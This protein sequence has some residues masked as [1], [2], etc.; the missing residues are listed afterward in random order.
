MD[1]W[2]P[3]WALPL[4]KERKLHVRMKPPATK[5]TRV[6]NSNGAS[7]RSRIGQATHAIKVAIGGDAIRERHQGAARGVGSHGRPIGED[8]RTLDHIAQTGIGG[9]S[10]L[11]LRGRHMPPAAEDNG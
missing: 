2:R 3:E 4:M 10:E 11:E 8:R 1:V 5:N 7:H 6:S 9:V